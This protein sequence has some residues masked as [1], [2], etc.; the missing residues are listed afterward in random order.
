LG[1]ALSSSVPPR[2]LGLEKESSYAFRKAKMAKPG[3]NGGKGGPT[4]SGGAFISTL[5]PEGGEAP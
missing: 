2:R 5:A 3:V 1:F 4:R